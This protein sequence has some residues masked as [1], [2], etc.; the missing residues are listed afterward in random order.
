MNPAEGIP[1]DIIAARNEAVFLSIEVNA[2]SLAVLGTDLKVTWELVSISAGDKK[3][4]KDDKTFLKEFENR[5]FAVIQPDRLNVSGAVYEVKAAVSYEPNEDR[6]GVSEYLFRIKT[7]RASLKITF[8]LEE[9]N[10]TQS[11]KGRGS[12]HGLPSPASPTRQLDLPVTKQSSLSE[13]TNS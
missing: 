8:C 6:D 10:I 12:R 3:R 11:K 2:C 13:K 5:A 7:E 4:S 9:M 1:A